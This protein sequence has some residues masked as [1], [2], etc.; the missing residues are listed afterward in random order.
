[1]EKPHYW[2]Y[3]LCLDCSK[4]DK[5]A[6]TDPKYLETWVKDLVL[7]I[8]MVPYGEPQILHFGHG[9]EHLSGWTVLQF[10]ETSNIMAHF[11][12]NT[13]EGYIDIFSCKKFDYDVAI[14]IVNSYFS[15]ER[16]S[17]T[18]LIRQA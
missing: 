8:D 1:M 10:I 3:H 12:D 15:P 5:E 16:I 2:G 13:Q 14:D 7:A 4:C 9:E 17:P 18:I 11:C 6:I